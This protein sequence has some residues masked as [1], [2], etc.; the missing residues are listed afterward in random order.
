MVKLKK[1]NGFS[2]GEMMVVVAIMVVLAAVGIV[3]IIS[4]LRSMTKMQYDDHAKEIFI[5]AQN[6]LAMAES[7]GYLGRDMAKKDD[8]TME[9]NEEPEVVGVKESTLI[10]DGQE[11]VYVFIVIDGSGVND[12]ASILNLMLPPGS[13]DEAVRGTGSYAIRYHKE[14]GQIL[15]VFYW[16]Q[17]GERYSHSYVNEYADFM[18]KRGDKSELKTYG[19]DKSVIGYYGGAEAQT[20]PRI[21][22]NPPEITVENAEKLTVTVKDNNAGNEHARLTLEITGVTSG[23]TETIVLA[24]NCKESAGSY[25]KVLDDI[26][27]SS[28]HFH[29]LFPGMI[30]G[31]DLMIRAFADSPDMLSNVAYS[32]QV[33]ANSIFG[34]GSVVSGS[35]TADIANIRH[36]EN[37]NISVSGVNNSTHA[38]A[39]NAK[40]TKARQSKDLSWPD[41]VSNT[42]GGTTGTI[43]Y[44]STELGCFLPVAF[45]VSASESF[46]FAYDGRNHSVS[47]VVVNGSYGGDSGLF[48]ALFKGSVDNLKLVDFSITGTNAG[49]LAGSIDGTKITNV[50]ALNGTTDMEPTITGSAGVGG[51][52]GSAIGNAS[53]SKCAAALVVK[54]TGGSAGGLVGTVTNASVTGCYSAGHTTDGAYGS[55][56]YN[57]TASGSAGGLVGSASGTAAIR[58]CYSTCSASGSA[59][60]GLAGSVTGSGEIAWCYAAGL[61]SGSTKGAFAGSDCAASNCW[62]FEIV[63]ELP[64]SSTGGYTYLDPLPGGPSEGIAALDAD[65]NAYNTFIGVAELRKE[66]RPYDGKLSEYY[67]RRY[68]LKTVAQLAAAATGAGD[69]TTKPS[70][71]AGDF[72]A[73][74]YGDWPA[75]ELWF[76]P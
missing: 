56:T 6:H 51:L 32:P 65:A 61:V 52:I 10:D 75:P 37:L 13:L 9:A 57:V 46:D 49:A 40:F 71:E 16:S 25:K 24:E 21:K 19:S 43:C 20:L 55:D 48:G 73:I 11:G 63:N 76:K 35:G 44:S 54:S 72:V 1:K 4:Y 29:D 3:A 33:G 42:T 47:G 66:A 60:G 8:G 2:I 62:Y 58:Y 39:G 50:L 17:S 22:L 68:E 59:A 5:A 7:Q 34:D 64:D 18:S 12:T 28:Q 53:I 14:A 38:K 36:L 30:P 67:T 69:A 15:D 31:E 74:H 23:V 41:F 27:T 26:T 45:P 70:I